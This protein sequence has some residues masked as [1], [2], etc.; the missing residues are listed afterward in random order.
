MAGRTQSRNFLTSSMGLG[1]LP[2]STTS[3]GQFTQLD[4]LTG[5]YVTPGM[6]VEHYGGGGPIVQAKITLAGTPATWLDDANTVWYIGKQIYNY[7]EGAL[8]SLG[9]V[10]DGTHSPIAT[11]GTLN[12]AT[13]AGDVAIGTATATTG[14]TLTGTEADIL[15]STETAAAVDSVSTIDAVSTA[16]ALTES[17]ARWFDG[18]ATAKDAFLNILI[19]D[20]VAIVAPIG[21]ID[22]VVYLTYLMLGDN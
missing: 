7:P 15:Q 17:G 16:T 12:A 4:K 20:D 6:S 13:F 5:L 11:S 22:C 1:T 2:T 21:T 19:D 18:T 14:A 3:T 9:A 10:I 8:L